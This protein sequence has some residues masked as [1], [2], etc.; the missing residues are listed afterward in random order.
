MKPLFALLYIVLALSSV[1]AQ[2]VTLY[3]IEYTSA[4]RA[5]F[6]PTGEIL[7]VK[8]ISTLADGRTA[9]EVQSVIEA[10]VKIDASTT[11]TLP[12]TEPPTT[13]TFD[14]ADT[15]IA[16]AT[17]HEV[18]QY[19]TRGNDVIV[20]NAKCSNRRED[21]SMICED[22]VE[23]V[24][25]GT[26]TEVTFQTETGSARPF[27]TLTGSSGSPGATS[28]T[29]GS[30]AASLSHSGEG[31]LAPAIAISFILGFQFVKSIL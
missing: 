28:A 26:S 16:D 27:Y 24:T 17:Q 29:T 9:Y 5:L 19:L 12:V 15:Y 20:V 10:T 3:G 1:S 21:G 8:P 25:N 30:N 18:N 31:N 11:S 14:T 7:T 13:T 22:R 23:V 6:S 2:D 4:S